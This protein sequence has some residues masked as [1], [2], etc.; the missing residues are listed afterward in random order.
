MSKAKGMEIEEM[1]SVMLTAKEEELVTK[2]IR[3]VIYGEIHIIVKGRRL[4]FVREIV[5]VRQLGKKDLY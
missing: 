5:R 2:V 1:R 4:E 3:N